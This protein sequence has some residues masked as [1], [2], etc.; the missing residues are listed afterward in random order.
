MN[1]WVRL[2]I[3]YV[4]WPTTSSIVWPHSPKAQCTNFWC[5]PL[6]ARMGSLQ[7]KSSASLRGEITWSNQL[8]EP[9][10]L[11]L[12]WLITAASTLLRVSF[13]FCCLPSRS[14][15]LIIQPAPDV[16]LWFD[17]KP[18]SI[19]WCSLSV[20][21]GTYILLR[22]TISGGALLILLCWINFP[23]CLESLPSQ[24]SDQMSLRAS[25]R[26]GI[27]RHCHLSQCTSI[28]MSGQAAGAGS[29]ACP[30]YGEISNTIW[31]LRC[32]S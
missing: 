28:R 10:W 7:W 17:R 22:L 26:L 23:C 25:G 6:Y 1:E 24:E 18:G 5:C 8:A 15:R 21:D 32:L 14:Q 9:H 30:E 13:Q 31:V 2:V 20:F 12:V 16:E 3:C 19:P 29:T 11:L 4:Y 27:R